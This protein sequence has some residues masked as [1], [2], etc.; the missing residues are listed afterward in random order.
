MKVLISGP[1]GSGKTSL[2]KVMQGF[3]LD[4]IGYWPSGRPYHGKY[5]IHMDKLKKAD[6]YLAFG[7]ANNI[8]EVSKLF[9]IKLWIKINRRTLKRRLYKR[10]AEHPAHDG[11][12]HILQSKKN[13]TLLPPDEGWVYIDGNGTIPEIVKEIRWHVRHPTVVLSSNDP[14]RRYHE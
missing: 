6:P 1:S 4:N 8:N 14:L 12:H 11:A 13:Q 7:I 2:C 10:W 3:D 5:L 9:E